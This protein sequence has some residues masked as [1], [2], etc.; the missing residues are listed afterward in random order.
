M[1]KRG[2]KSIVSDLDDDSRLAYQIDYI[3]FY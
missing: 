3:I 1:S 2:T